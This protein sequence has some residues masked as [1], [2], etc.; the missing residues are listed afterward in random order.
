MDEPLDLNNILKKLEEERAT[1]LSHLDQIN[2]KPVSDLREMRE[3]EDRVDLANGKCEINKRDSLSS[4]YAKQL[5]TIERAIKKIEE[6]TYGIC[7]DCHQPI[8]P[9]RLKANPHAVDCLDCRSR[10]VQTNR[11]PQIQRA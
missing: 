4:I 8:N 11:I 5:P 10:A 1:A 7:D 6:G 3:P 2:H 9:E